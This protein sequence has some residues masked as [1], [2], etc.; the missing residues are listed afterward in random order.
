MAPRSPSL[1][2]IVPLFLFF[3]F[4]SSLHDNLLFANSQSYTPE[5]FAAP[6]SAFI[7]GKVMYVH[8]GFIGSEQMTA[9]VFSLD[10][11]IS[12]DVATPAYKQLPNGIKTGWHTDTLLND[13]TTFLI[14]AESSFYYYNIHNG[15]LTR[16]NISN[17]L[18]NA[19]F[20]RG[21]AM[22]N[23]RTGRVYVP[24]GHYVYPG[25]VFSL[26]RFDPDAKKIELMSLPVSQP[27]VVQ[28][29]AAWSDYLD[30]MFFQIAKKI[31][32]AAKCSQ[33][34][35]KLSYSIMVQ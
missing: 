31:C 9:Q 12:W 7:D 22:T 23:P 15:Q 18:V 33:I 25:D 19:T 4:T 6:A 29:S 1:L 3:L 13:S 30:A 10:L 20:S 28:Y 21:K 26:L 5:A 8:G 27:S 17:S 35:S 11:S 2:T 32:Y 14:L 34:S 24:Y 16:Y